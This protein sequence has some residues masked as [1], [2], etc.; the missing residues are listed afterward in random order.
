VAHGNLSGYQDELVEMALAGNR[1]VASALS[2]MYDGGLGVEKD[3]T[4]MWA[5]LR[6]A[7][8]G[9]DPLEENEAWSAEINRD[10]ADAF[11]FYL[12]VLDETIPMV[13]E[14][15]RY[16]SGSATRCNWQQRGLGRTRTGRS[17]VSWWLGILA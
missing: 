11:E 14:T 16:P 1:Q 6:W 17:L 5:W 4:K 10:V 3:Q 7:H 12:P 9:C 15:I 13:G 8:D 2:R